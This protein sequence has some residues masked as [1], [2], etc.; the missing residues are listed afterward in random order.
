M[1]LALILLALLGCTLAAH[2]VPLRK[3]TSLREKM[4]RA[5][6]WGEYQKKREMARAASRAHGDIP[7]NDY[8]DVSQ[9]IRRRL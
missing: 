6:T 3:I 5:G 9:N 8:S 1:K 4:T 2:K 7:E